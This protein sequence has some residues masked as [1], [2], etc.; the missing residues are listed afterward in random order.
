MHMLDVFNHNRL[1]RSI[2][3]RAGPSEFARIDRDIGDTLKLPQWG[4]QRFPTEPLHVRQSG[5]DQ[6]A[7]AGK[8][9]LSALAENR[10]TQHDADGWDS[11]DIAFLRTFLGGI[12]ASEILVVEGTA[13]PICW[14]IIHLGPAYAL[15]PDGIDGFLGYRCC[16]AF[17]GND[18]R[19]IGQLR[20]IGAALIRRL[21]GPAQT[22]F[23]FVDDDQI[24]TAAEHR[25]YLSDWLGAGFE[26]LHQDLPGI[27]LAGVDELADY[28]TGAS[29]NGGHF[30]CHGEAADRSALSHLIQ[31]RHLNKLRTPDVLK[32][33]DTS[34][35]RQRKARRDRRGRSLSYRLIAMHVCESRL[36]FELP[37]Q[38]SLLEGLV[39]RGAQAGVGVIA[40]ICEGNAALFSTAFYDAL[41]AANASVGEAFGKALRERLDDGNPAFLSYVLVGDPGARL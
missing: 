25:K 5:V 15:R 12:G 41:R 19:S 36:P 37:A 8:D 3:V 17:G 29:R 11:G 30:I 32:A 31:V 14:N 27:T 1:A 26:P 22:R 39:R 38:L 16:L 10:P 9:L 20:M 7:R 34:A 33:I 13:L 23:A 18:G 4:S 40:Q 28:L 6:L 24:Q 35:R 21:L 2:P